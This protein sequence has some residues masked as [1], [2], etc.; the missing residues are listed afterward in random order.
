MF[1]N[2]HDLKLCQEN[3]IMQKCDLIQIIS[4]P[5]LNKEN[6]AKIIIDDDNVT[7]HENMK[8]L[9]FTICQNY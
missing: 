3:H 7:E 5:V 6:I 4:L 8:A 1:A 9:N 2:C